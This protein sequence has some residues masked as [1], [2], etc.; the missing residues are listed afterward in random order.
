LNLKKYIGFLIMIFLCTACTNISSSVQGEIDAPLQNFIS[1]RIK[2]FSEKHFTKLHNCEVTF[3]EDKGAVSVEFVPDFG[4]ITFKND[5]WHWAAAHAMNLTYVFPEIK[6][7][8]YTVFDDKNN[9]L[10]DLEIDELG[11]RILPEK[12]FG[13]RGPG[14]YRHCFT[15]VELTKIG[16]ELPLDEDFFDGSQLP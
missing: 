3:S 5:I 12:F 13:N 14:D 8:R 9:K 10:M 16:N 4:S 11:I 15:K 2:M 7:Y 6:D 1:E